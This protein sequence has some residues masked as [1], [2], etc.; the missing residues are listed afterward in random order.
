MPPSQLKTLKKSLRDQGIV[1]PQK[2]KKQKKQLA[3]NGISKEK[4]VS[5]TE[6]TNAIRDQF[7]PFEYTWSKGPKFDV[8]TIK[9]NA[10]KGG[11]VIGRPYVK[12]SREAEIVRWR[13]C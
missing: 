6:A 12:R 13:L 4:R 8:T 1:G 10:G 5:R 2:S 3:Q 11:I 9:D 7:R